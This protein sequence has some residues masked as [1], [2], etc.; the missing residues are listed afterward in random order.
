MNNSLAW[1]ILLLL[2]LASCIT[3]HDTVNDRLVRE[4]SWVR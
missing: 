4:S 1:Q 2:I 3:T